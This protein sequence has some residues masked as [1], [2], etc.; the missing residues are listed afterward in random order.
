MPKIET[1]RIRVADKTSDQSRQLG[2]G[3]GLQKVDRLF[4][5]IANYTYDWETW[6]SEEIKPLWINPAVER[7]T[8]YS[9]QECLAFSDYPLPLVHEDDRHAIKRYLVTAAQGSSDNDVEFRIRKKDGTLGWGAVSWQTIFDEYGRPMGFRTSVRDITVRKVAEQALRRSMS[10]VERADRAKSK[11]LAAASHDLRQPLQA[12]AMFIGTLDRKLDDPDCQKIIDLA[13]RSLAAANQLLNGLLDISRLDAGVIVPQPQDFAIQDV[14]DQLESEYAGIVQDK[15]LDLRTVACSAIVRS[16]PTVLRSILQNLIS[17]A[18]RYT[19]TGRIL[20]GCRRR[21]RS[22]VIQVW[23]TGI[24]VQG[25]HLDMI[26]DE[27]FQVGNPERDRT[28][29]LG[30]GLAIVKRQAKLLKVKIDKNSK[31]GEG[32]VFSVTIPLSGTT[33][34]VS[35]LDVRPDDTSLAGLSI[36]VI[37]DEPSQLDAIRSFLSTLHCNVITATNTAEAMNKIAESG[38]TVD[39]II[40]DYRLRGEETGVS[41]I[42]A[43]CAEL[44]PETPGLLLTGDTEPRLL[45]EMKS[46]G[47]LLVNKPVD[48]E[49]LVK[50]VIEA[51]RLQP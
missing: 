22:L 45:K 33:R 36:A 30:L 50:K 41:A 43:I 7:M 8:G 48:P 27:F 11:F 4:E 1:Q 40:A 34:P 3:T 24:G 21:S 14:L 12:I 26:F 31:A 10:D 39:A 25:D 28:R 49:E 44:G 19:E 2:M 15:G 51:I 35:R 23:D 20:F 38:E 42:K 17:N 32:S 18:V 13:G 46:S 6:F 29:G 16:D 47:Y 9:V 5:T 37:D